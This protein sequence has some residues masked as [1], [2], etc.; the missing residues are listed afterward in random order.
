MPPSDRIDDEGGIHSDQLAVPAQALI[1]AEIDPFLEFL[2][3][4]I[5][6]KP[7]WL[8]LRETAGVARYL[9]ALA[10]EAPATRERDGVEHLAEVIWLT[11]LDYGQIA[12]AE[13]EEAIQFLKEHAR[14]EL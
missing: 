1:P 4:G 2:F 12:G 8:K 7:K 9:K 3:S 6:R 11:M 14:T 10:R 5:V 13:K